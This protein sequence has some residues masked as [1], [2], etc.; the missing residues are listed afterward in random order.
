MSSYDLQARVPLHGVPVS[1]WVT[2]EL[3]EE[4]LASLQE[5]LA[6]PV[7]GLFGPES[8][9]WRVGRCYL[10]AVLGSGRALLLQIAHP[11]V[12]QGIDHHSSTRRDPIGRA[13]GTFT[14][15][16]SMTLG[17]LPHAL[18]VAR[19]LHTRHDKVQ[20]TLDRAAGG[21]QAGDSYRANEV[22]AL[23]WVHATLWDSLMHM[24]ELIVERVTDQERERYYRETKLFAH[25]FG[26][27]ESALPPDWRTFQSY[28]ERMYTSDQLAV[29]PET[30]E[31]AK[32]LYR[33]LT[34]V[35]KP[36]MRWGE[37][38]TAATLPANLAR[39]FGLPISARTLETYD[40]TV[41]C[42]R[43]LHRQLPDR[44]RYSPTY[45]EALARI[46]GRRSDLFTR[47]CTRAMF[48]KWRVVS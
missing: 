36:V 39:Q 23:V 9:M 38:I 30:L 29:T 45:F 32:F 44:L 31:L 21:F 7:V 43:A 37:A 42:F 18:S 46:Q 33:P 26:I 20:G 10:P 12:T 5:N 15:V 34:P 1:Q 6:D 17:S 28:N 47:A 14:N 24:Y 3:L 25:L 13:R 22:N 41:R 40:R 48:G 8:M 2:R 16:L 11:W 4:R 35:L 27:P 19:A